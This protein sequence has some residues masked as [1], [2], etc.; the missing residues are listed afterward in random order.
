[1]TIE[2]ILTTETESSADKLRRTFPGVLVDEEWRGRQVKL[3]KTDTSYVL[4]IS[5]PS[6]ELSTV[7]AIKVIENLKDELS[8]ARTRY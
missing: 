2:Q 1:M 4:T 3:T 8:I 7:G 6:Q 5:N